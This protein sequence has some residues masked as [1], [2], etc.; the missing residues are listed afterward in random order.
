MASPVR[1]GVLISGSGRTL[2]NFIELA[3]P[4]KAV[5]RSPRLLTSV[6]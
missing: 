1:L 2:E 3:G 6:L 4:A 5:R